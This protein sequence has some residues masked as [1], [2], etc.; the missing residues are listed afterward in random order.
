MHYLLANALTVGVC[1][2]ANLIAADRAV[3]KPVCSVLLFLV[4]AWSSPVEA[5]ELGADT[6]EA[7]DRYVRVTESRMDAELRGQV[8][9]LAV[10]RLDGPARQEA[11]SRLQRGD[12]VVGRLVT[13][14]DGR[15]TVSPR[16]F[17][18]LGPARRSSPRDEPSP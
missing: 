11:Y 2:V 9:F 7:F 1:A 8:P 14:D 10:D 13:Q 17:I 4:V 5:A 3:F 16:G 6:L 18:H 15:T 12:I